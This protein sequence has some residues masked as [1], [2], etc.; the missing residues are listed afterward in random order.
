[1]GAWGP[2]LYQDDVT[3]DVK[4]DYLDWL[5]TG[6]SNEEALSN[7]IDFNQDLIEDEEDGPLFWFALAD[8]QW[9]YGRLT[10]FVKEK[11][12]EYIKCGSDLE[13]WKYD[14]AQYK[15]RQIVIANLEKKLR[16]P[17][18]KPKKIKKIVMKRATWN[19]GDVLLYKIQVKGCSMDEKIKNSKW[20]N[21]YVL[22]KVVGVDRF[23]IGSLPMDK[24]FDEVN[25]VSVFNWVGDKKPNIETINKLSFLKED[26]YNAKN[27]DVSYLL[28][29]D[30]K[31]LKIL[32][33]EVISRED[34][35][36]NSKYIMRTI[37]IS[38]H[39]INT[40]DYSLI[41]HLCKAEEEKVLVNEKDKKYNL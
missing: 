23:N 35:V 36:D 25:V 10:D 32:D 26:R 7:V 21:K 9:K 28:R 3:C 38:W 4:D 17:Q 18:P 22:M 40:L 8:T 39:N 34:N 27:V 29:F 30:K 37:G 13:R 2:G 15:K 11:A 20:C 24:Y 16:L 31:E 33:I 19:V 14:R 41:T 5:R 6:A 12:L 1:M